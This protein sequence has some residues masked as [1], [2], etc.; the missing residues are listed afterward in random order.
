MDKHFVIDRFDYV[1][2]SNDAGEY[3]MLYDEYSELCDEITIKTTVMTPELKRGWLGDLTYA[4]Y[5]GY[6]FD[7]D[8]KEE[9]VFKCCYH[10]VLLVRIEARHEPNAPVSWTYTFLKA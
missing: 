4:T 10:D 6:N 7:N 2:L 1:K 3:D 5:K 8:K 9:C